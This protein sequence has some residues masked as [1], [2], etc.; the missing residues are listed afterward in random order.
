MPD[1]VPALSTD[2]DHAAAFAYC[3]GYIRALM[4]VLATTMPDAVQL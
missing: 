1:H 2:T 4:Q 3:F